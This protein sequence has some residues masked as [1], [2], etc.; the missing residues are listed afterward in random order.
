[1][2]APLLDTLRAA[3]HE[4]AD[5]DRAP[6]MQAYMK[7]SMPFHGVPRP[8]RAAVEKR[9]L[10]AAALPS[11]A[12]WRR[13]VL[14]LWRGARYREERYGAISLAQDRRARCFH[15]MEALP[16]FE[17]M[18]VS[19]AWWD[20]V[21]PLATHSLGRMLR[22][23][24]AEVRAVML[25]WSTDEDMWKRR[26]AILCQLHFKGETDLELLYACIDPS[27]A[28][29]EFFLRKAIG[30]AL[31]QHARTDPGE[32][33]RWVRVNEGR[34]SPLSRREAMKHLEG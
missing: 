27:L 8:A 31:R 32:V 33:A 24:P 13:E 19:G 21:D 15:D 16:M 5:P 2:P 26:T 7:T 1:M 20:L 18:I 11:A 4:A 28:S 6:A 3:L 34:L 12:V 10:G 29:K 14:G 22:E 30:W 23:N 9:V 17:E 25:G